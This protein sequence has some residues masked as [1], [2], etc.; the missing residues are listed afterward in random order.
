VLHSVRPEYVDRLRA[1]IAALL[2]EEQGELP[3][4][5]PAR[6]NMLAMRSRLAAERERLERELEAIPSRPVIPK[7][8]VRREEPPPPEPLPEPPLELPAEEIAHEEPALALYE[9]PIIIEKTPLE[10]EASETDPKPD[11]L[12]D[13]PLS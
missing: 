9:E 13:S 4:A 5:Q 6:D 11:G 7:V 2:A 10:S 3:K 12:A 8:R 1:Q